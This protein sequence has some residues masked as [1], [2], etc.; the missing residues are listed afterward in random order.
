MKDKTFDSTKQVLTN[1]FTPKH[2]HEYEKYVFRNTKQ[3]ADENMDQFFTRLRQL[4]VNC[5]FTDGTVKD[6]IKSQIIQ[7]CASS[8]LRKK[9]LRDNLELR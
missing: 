3:K 7:G 6:E 1:Y 4:A 8:T 9:A 2:N 5:G